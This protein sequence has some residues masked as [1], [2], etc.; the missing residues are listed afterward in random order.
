MFRFIIPLI[1]FGFSIMLY[2]GYTKPNLDIIALVEKDISFA[3][4]TLSI[5]KDAIE[6]KRQD[7]EK[8]RESILLEDREKVKR[9][10]PSVDEFDEAA[11]INDINNIAFR[12]GMFLRGVSVSGLSTGIKRSDERGSSSDISAQYEA[13]SMGFGV[14]NTYTGFKKFLKDLEKSEQLLDITTITFGSA[15]DTEESDY[16]ITINAYYWVP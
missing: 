5:K 3:T 8:A 11:F 14:T 6:I 10:V 1:F 16:R 9:L 13:V 12:H 15:S 7:L 4:S 2:F